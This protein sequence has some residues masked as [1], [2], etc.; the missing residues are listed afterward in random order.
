MAVVTGNK[1]IDFSNPVNRSA[2]LPAS[3]GDMQT[4]VADL[5]RKFQNMETVLEKKADIGSLKSYIRMSSEAIAIG[6]KDIVLIGDVTIAKIVNEQNGTTNGTVSALL[7]R[8]IGNRVQ[9]GI[10]TSTNWGAAEGTAW[11][12]DDGIIHIG[13]SDNPSLYYDGN[14]NLSIAGTLTANSV[15]ASTVTITGVSPQVTLGGINSRAAAGYFL[16]QQIEVSGTTI[17]KGTIVPQDSGA[18]K[19]GSITW[20]PTTGAL[21]GGTGVATTEFGIFAAASGSPTFSLNAATGA[22]VFAGS[23]S[24]ATGTFAGSLSA[25]S[26]SFTGTLS[27]A[28]G[29]FA[30][31]LSAAT[32]TFSGSLSAASGT[33]SGDINTSGRILAT[34]IYSELGYNASVT[35]VPSDPS[36][37][38]LLGIA[39]SGFGILGVQNNG[40][41][42]I[43]GRSTGPGGIAVYCNGYGSDP[44]LHVQ[45]VMTIS[46]TTLVSNLNADMVDGVH[47]SSFMV[48]NTAVLSNL[49]D[50]TTW[51]KF[52]T[53]VDGVNVASTIYVRKRAW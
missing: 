31:S 7:T 20:N 11:D 21:T 23:L 46:N 42:G 32:G 50:S 19:V 13:G 38:G 10:I 18:L 40:G 30:G 29:T 37:I 53:S 34:G 51:S 3:T 41:H 6:A 26:G 49:A 2:S 8:I 9:T 47:A 25:V 43:E 52:E 22:A 33:F 16:Q 35:G 45:G 17:L 44:A 12:L 24:A 15:I 5:Q 39:G 27:G 4:V 48:I 28:T 1:S 36:K 14:G